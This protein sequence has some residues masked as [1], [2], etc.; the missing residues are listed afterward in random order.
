MT[1]YYLS[2]KIKFKIYFFINF[3]FL[4]VSENQIQNFKS[5]RINRTKLNQNKIIPDQIWIWSGTKIQPNIPKCKTPKKT[6]TSNQFQSRTIKLLICLKTVNHYKL[7]LWVFWYWSLY[8][9]GNIVETLYSWIN[10]FRTL[11]R[12]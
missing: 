1:S 5:C 4:M 2:P 9:W 8:L 10:R 3:A 11:F 6:K 12:E 7:I